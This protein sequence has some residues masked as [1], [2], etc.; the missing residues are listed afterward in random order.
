MHNYIVVM[1][2]D[3]VIV[4]V[5]GNF[6]RITSK[7][8]PSPPKTQNIAELRRALFTIGLI[9][10]HFDLADIVADTTAVRNLLCC[11]LIGVCVVLN[12]VTA[13]HDVRFWATFKAS[14]ARRSRSVQTWCSWLMW[15]LPHGRR[16]PGWGEVSSLAAQAEGTLVTETSD[17]RWETCPNRALKISDNNVAPRRLLKSF[18]FAPVLAKS[19]MFAPVLA[20]QLRD[21]VPYWLMYYTNLCIDFE[22]YRTVSMHQEVPTSQVHV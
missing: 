9:M 21:G 2:S 19:F 16:Q 13:N 5:V 8:T 20:H 3:Y 15:R 10:K 11:G 12:I 18:M 22:V 1:Q 6:S 14:E 17:W 7:N 4:D